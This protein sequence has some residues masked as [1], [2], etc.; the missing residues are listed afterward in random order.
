MEVHMS[1][2]MRTIAAMGCSA[3]FLI[4]C[5]ALAQQPAQGAGQPAKAPQ[6]I[7]RPPL[8]FREDW[9][10]DPKVPNPGPEQE[11][12]VGQGDL[13]DPNLELKLYGD[14]IG[15]VVVFQGNDDITFLMTLLCTANC[16]VALRDKNNN[17]DLSGLAKLRWRIR[18]NGFHF[19]RPIVKLADGTWLVGDHAVGYSND[20]VET[21]IPFVDVRWR[22]LDIENVVEARDGKWV[23]NPD[24]SKVEEI[25]FTDLMRGSGHGMGGG[26]R[27]DWVEVYGKPVPRAAGSA[28]SA[29]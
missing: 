19:L 28:N 15:P 13:S 25:G 21:E 9:K 29:K 1:S 20:W 7:Q 26:S 23:D 14:K 4:A 10:L 12:T 27:I 22:N 17:V 3:I 16:A 5:N 2:L 11:H 8:F 24:L 18:E 6:K